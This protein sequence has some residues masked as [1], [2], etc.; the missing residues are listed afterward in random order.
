MATDRDEIMHM[1]MKMEGAHYGIVSNLQQVRELMTTLV[2]IGKAF[3]RVISRSQV[4]HAICF[5]KS[6]LSFFTCFL[7]PK[8]SSSLRPTSVSKVYL[9]YNMP[10]LQ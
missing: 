10:S 3:E 2:D 5:V 7:F 1:K 4:V 9:V 6:S 8:I